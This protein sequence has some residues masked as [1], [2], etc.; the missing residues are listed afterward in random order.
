MTSALFYLC[1]FVYVLTVYTVLY[2]DA[3]KKDVCICVFV[4]FIYFQKNKKA[5]IK[6]LKQENENAKKK[7]IHNIH[8]IHKPSFE[9]FH[10][11]KCVY[12]KQIHNKYTTNTQSNS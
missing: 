9:C 11:Q 12:A 5:H 10:I 6:I 1:I 7:D 4:Y 8:N 3:L 2:V